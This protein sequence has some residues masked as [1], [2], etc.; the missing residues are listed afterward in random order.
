MRMEQLKYLVDVAETKSMTKTAERLFV[1]PQA[2]SKNIK[3]LEMELDTVFLVRTSMGAELTHVGAAV[4]ALA[5]DML[6]K[7]LQMKQMIAA[8]KKRTHYQ[9]S[10][11]IRICSTSAI[12]NML[13]PGIIAKFVQMGIHI[14]PRIYMVDTLQELL[15]H[16]EQGLCDL[17]LATYNEE[18]L[19]NRFAPYQYSLDMDLLAQ[20]ELVVVMNRESAAGREVLSVHDFMAH[21]CSMFCMMPVDNMMQ[22]AESTHVMRSNDADFH[23]AMLKEADAYVLMPRRAYEHFF[24]DEAYRA[25]PM[26]NAKPSLLHA[27]IY[28]KDAQEELR[29]FAKFVR[30]GMQKE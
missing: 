28:R 2:V 11:T 6:E 23:R 9:Q 30:M 5:R 21:L 29:A 16:A 25:I 22:R 20:D 19:F 4:V 15:D 12:A 7:E 13:L 3:Q 26:E 14:V 8:D 18:A 17:A 1:T 27:A 10:F 24:S